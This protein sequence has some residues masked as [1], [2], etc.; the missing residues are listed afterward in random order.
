MGSKKI[1][2]VIVLAI[3]ITIGLVI[4]SSSNLFPQT[5]TEIMDTDNPVEE[6]SQT[7]KEITKVITKTI[8]SDGTVQELTQTITSEGT[9]QDEVIIIQIDRE[10]Y[11]EGC[12]DR[13][14]GMAIFDEIFHMGRKPTSEELTKIER[15]AIN[16]GGSG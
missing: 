14:L 15:C 5:I 8:T 1:P 2:I 3:I 4:S 12:A 16:V 13:V 10:K 9:V 7:I 6:V 11:D